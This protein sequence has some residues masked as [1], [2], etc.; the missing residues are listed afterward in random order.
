MLNAPGP[1]VAIKIKYILVLLLGTSLI[2]MGGL[3]L[4]FKPQNTLPVQQQESK[5]LAGQKIVIDP[6]HGGVDS[7][8]HYQE[9]VL[10]K[11]I[12]LELALSLREAL[13]HLG[14]EV[15][16]TR[17]DDRDTSQLVP[18]SPDTRYK[19]D[20]QGRVKY[21]NESEAS[22]F[23]SLH[24]N[25]CEVATVRGPI[26]FYCDRFQENIYLAES[27]QKNLNKVAPGGPEIGG[28]IHRKI[29]EGDFYLLKETIV[30]GVIVETGFLTN[31]EE[32]A[33]LTDSSYI[34]RLAGAI[35]QGVIEYGQ[36]L[37][38]IA[39]SQQKQEVITLYGLYY[40]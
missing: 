28:Y 23:L 19:R 38:I 16:L 22:F 37:P 33:L 4:F 11:Q 9:A 20:M 39:D 34:N 3:F 14:A 30:P 18:G 36:L 31:P 25:S 13:E 32:R 1:F 2:V 10:E 6:G 5:P 7:G 17:E 35:S 15:L 26:V 24:V 21:I 40:E 27:V 12:N 29:K 8:V